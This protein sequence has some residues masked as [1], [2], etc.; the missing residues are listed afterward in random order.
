[1]VI[2]VQELRERLFSRPHE[3]TKRRIDWTKWIGSPT[4]WLALILSVVS[5]YFSFFR[6]N[7]DIQVIVQDGIQVFA[8]PDD[9]EVYFPQ[10]HLIMIN[11]G[12]RPAAISDFGL[13]LGQIPVD[14]D[15][16]SCPRQVELVYAFDGLVLKP[17]DMIPVSLETFKNGLE[18]KGNR[19][20]VEHSDWRREEGKYVLTCLMFRIATPDGISQLV[21][22]PLSKSYLTW[23]R[24]FNRKFNFDP[25]R[26][27]FTPVVL[28]KRDRPAFFR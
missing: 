27:K 28:I 15:W 11:A 21:G 24:F 9:I 8:H 20:I 17:G 26:D 22:T 6:Q 12:N 25:P 1:M 2:T 23:I 3:P 4:A 19:V 14:E 16:N 18:V 7:D 5:T 13:Y 10:Q